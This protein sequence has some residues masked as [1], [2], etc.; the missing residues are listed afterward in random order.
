VSQEDRKREF[1]KR[2]KENLANDDPQQED[3]LVDESRALILGP[4]KH[5]EGGFSAFAGVGYG[6][7][8]GSH[9]G[10]QELRPE[11]VDEVAR[12]IHDLSQTACGRRVA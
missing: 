5:A 7:G 10:T 3:R 12:I 2:L 9:Y 6:V 4:L 8:G 1:F 11:Q